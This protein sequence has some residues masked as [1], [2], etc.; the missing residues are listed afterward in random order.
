VPDWLI[1]LIAAGVLAGAEA[2]SG[3]FVLIMLAGGA[4]AAAVAA[5]LGAPLAVE[6][7]VAILGTLLL[8]WL[9]RPVALRHLNPGPLALTG[10]DAL[11]GH[12]AV[13][14]RDVTRDGGRVKLNGA[15]WSARAADPK[16]ELPPGTVV[17][18]LAIDGA[19]AVVYRDPF[20]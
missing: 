13:V 1:W 11:V 20:H 4:G 3:T 9:A 17:S 10:T 7:V 2:V 12:D 6:I 15:E 14:L 5:A 18:V 19:T 8:L 16:Q